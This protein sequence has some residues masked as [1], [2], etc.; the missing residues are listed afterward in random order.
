MLRN[1]QWINLTCAFDEGSIYWPTNNL[2][3]HDT[4]IAKMTEGGYFYSSCY[5][6]AEEHRGTHFEAAIHFAKHL[7]TV[8]QISIDPLYFHGIHPD[9]L[10]A[11]GSWIMAFSMK[12]KEERT[13]QLRIAVFIP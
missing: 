11:T 9:E 7:K 8:A 6:S 1:V 13:P 5:F 10:P 4:L 2:F 3:T 12:I